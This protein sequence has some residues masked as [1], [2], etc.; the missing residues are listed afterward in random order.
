MQPYTPQ[1]KPNTASGEISV[2]PF[3]SPDSSIQTIVGL[4]EV[5]LNAGRG[6][7]LQ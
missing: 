6:F 3:F 2:T 4:I 1:F 7:P 5:R